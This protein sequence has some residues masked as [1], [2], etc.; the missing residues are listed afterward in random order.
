MTQTISKA[1]ALCR[2]FA[3]DENGATAIEYSIIAA[4]VGGAVITIV[5]TLG[6]NT[7]TKLFDKIYKLL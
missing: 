1:T 6:T 3:S 5:L 7:K 4:G 2:R